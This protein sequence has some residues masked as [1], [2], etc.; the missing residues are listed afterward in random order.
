MQPVT[1]TV[2]SILLEIQ[3]S[4]PSFPLRGSQDV[5]NM[6]SLVQDPTR[7]SQDIMAQVLS[8][9]VEVFQQPQSLSPHP[10]LR[11]RSSQPCCDKC[12]EHVREPF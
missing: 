3:A 1:S 7:T 9:V 8:K 2:T 10:C 4:L 5:C 11:C 12:G 6:A